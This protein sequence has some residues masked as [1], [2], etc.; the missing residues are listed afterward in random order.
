MNLFVDTNIFLDFY[1]FSDDDLDELKKLIDL[2]TKNKI[3]LIITSQVV[4]EIKRNRDSKVTDAYK[5]FKDSKIELGLPQIC[6]GYGEFIKIT[7]LLV[8]LKQQKIELDKKLRKDIQQ[9]TLKADFIINQLIR[10]AKVIKTE[11][12]VNEAK[13]RYDL[14]NPPGKDKSYGDS[15]TWIALIS[16][17]ENK[18]DLFF[19]SDDKDYK[20]PFDEYAFNS[21]LLDEW[22]EKKKSEF[23]FY[24]KLSSFFNK[25]HKDIQLKVEREKN[26]LINALAKSLSFASTHHIISSLSEYVSFTDEQIRELVTIG[27]DNSQVYQI[28]GD[29]DIKEFY[30]KLMENKDYLFEDDVLPKLL[31]RMRGEE[32][33]TGKENIVDKDVIPF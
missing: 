7:K 27:L 21:F 15:I 19:I 11:K 12:Y 9:R 26:K 6:K 1:H 16:E 24:T 25:H 29:P 2:I 17:L 8:E 28:L 33:N 30:E 23:F 4:D 3:T 18:K 10:I 22:K 14:G 20:S 13:R 32:D 5:K 31:K